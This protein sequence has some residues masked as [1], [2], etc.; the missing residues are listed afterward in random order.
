MFRFKVVAITIVIAV[1][2]GLTACA[3]SSNP[4][5]QKQSAQYNAKVEAALKTINTS[6]CGSLAVAWIDGNQSGIKIITNNDNASKESLY[7]I[8]SIT[9][10]L[11]GIGFALAISEGK[12]A[13][14]SKL[15]DSVNF[16]GDVN[17]LKDVTLL[18]LATHTSGLPR[19]PA[20]QFLANGNDQYSEF[21]DAKLQIAMPQTKLI[22]GIDFNY[23]NLGFGLLGMAVSGAYNQDYAS[24]I[25]EKVLRPLGMNDAVASNTFPVDK[26]LPVYK[27]DCRETNTWTFQNTLAGAGSVKANIQDMSLLL[28][29]LLNPK[30]DEL[31]KAIDFASKAKKSTIQN[32]DVGLGW[33]SSVDSRWVYHSG[34]TGGSSSFIG[35][36]KDKNRGI[37]LLFNKFVDGDLTQAGFEYLRAQ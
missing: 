6:T 25:E 37:V 29:A 17:H 31:G 11:T 1:S 26:V 24:F 7:E 33:F 9:K 16:T 12:L 13:L 21:D 15:V 34:G 3:P 18:E 19:K 10:G 35:I 2:V 14:D 36:N 22:T 5:P 8:A 4:T 20:V 28:E 32:G 23:S 30:D 27:N